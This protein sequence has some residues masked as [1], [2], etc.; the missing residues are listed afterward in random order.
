MNQGG[1]DQ[2]VQSREEKKKGWVRRLYDWVLG[3]AETPSGPTA[4][5]ALSFAEASF[6]PIPPDP[7][8]MALCLGAIKKS[9]RFAAIATAASVVGGIGGYLIGAGAW[10]ALGGFFFEYVPGVTP[11]AFQDIQAFYDRW[12]F[13]A[14]FMAGLTPFPYKVFTLSAGVFAINFPV[15]FLASVLSRG[16]RFFAEAG[17]LYWKGPSISRFIDKYF[18]LLAW[19]FVAL[20]VAGFLALEFLL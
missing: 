3:W 20:I 18:N 17:L 19:L 2:K 15:F 6:F 14:I 12:D 9:L 11:E 13:L 7:L 8:L 1:K 5:A 16:L 4:L 10:Q